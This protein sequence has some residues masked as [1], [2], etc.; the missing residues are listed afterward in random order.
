LVAVIFPLSDAALN[1]IP[2]QET[3]RSPEMPILIEVAKFVAV[4]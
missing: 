3:T 2:R 4:V 1:R